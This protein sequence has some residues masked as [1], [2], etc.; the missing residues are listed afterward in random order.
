M[1]AGRPYMPDYPVEAGPDGLLPWAWAVERLTASR[2][3]W[4]ATTWP[5][6]RPHVSPL[7]G[8]WH[9]G[10]LWLSCGGRSRKARNLG[11]DPRCTVTTANPEEP[12]ILDGTAERLTTLADAETYAAL[13][14]AKYDAEQDAAFY[15]AN[16][17]Y[18]VTPRTVLGMAEAAF[19]TSPTRWTPDT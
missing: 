1:E 2:H 12:V 19:T 4:L 6:G 11:R 16:A 14:R 8:A 9:E 13:A 15:A 10:A 7:W 5:D 17:L 18:R 3:Y